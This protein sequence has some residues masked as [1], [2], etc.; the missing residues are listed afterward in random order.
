LLNI[1]TASSVNMSNFFNFCSSL[2]TVPLFNTVTVTSMSNM[3]ANCSS[4]QTIP[5]FNTVAVT[6]MSGMFSG[7]ISLNSIPALVTTAVISSGNFNNMISSCN[8]LSRIE[9]RNFRFTFSITNCKLS[10][11]AL[12]EIYT[13]LPS[14][15]GQTITVTG[16][17]GTATDNPSIATAKGWTVSG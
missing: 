11:T 4:L 8:S 6:N 15:S 1:R 7:C 9:A 5:L 17:Y 10:A 14:V 2:Q 12:N 3:F 13:N 16:N